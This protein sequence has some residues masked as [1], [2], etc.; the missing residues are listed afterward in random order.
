MPADKINTIENNMTKL[1]SN[2]EHMQ[3]DI[4]KINDKL[5]D[6]CKK[7]ENGYV[8]KEIYEIET[9]HIKEGVAFCKGVI[10][11]GAGIFVLYILSEV[12]NLL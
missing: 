9:A 12:F 11:S 8:R 3:K 4:R 6:I 5:T 2:V 1:N 10:Y 7:M